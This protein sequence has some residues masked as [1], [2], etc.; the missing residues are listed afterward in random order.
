MAGK[1]KMRDI[2]ILLPGL[3]GSVLEKDG[4]DIWAATVEA[5]EHL[6]FSRFRSLLDLEMEPGNPDD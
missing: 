5:V 2:V 6:F 3:M 4:K 1:I